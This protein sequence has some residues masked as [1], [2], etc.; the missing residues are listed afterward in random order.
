MD[1]VTFGVEVCEDAWYAGGPHT[2]QALMGRAQ[3][4]VDIN[5]SRSRG[6]MAVS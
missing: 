4:I 1:N 5:S 3:L 2:L 6:Q